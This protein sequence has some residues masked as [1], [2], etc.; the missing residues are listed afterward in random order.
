[1]KFRLD[2]ELVRRGLARSREEA[3]DF[4]SQGFVLV[5]GIRATKIASQVAI[6]D[7]IVVKDEG[8]RFVSRGGTKLSGALEYFGITSLQ[9]KIVLDAGASTGGFTDVALQLGATKVFAVDVGYGQLA[10]PL[11][12]NPQVE[13]IDRTN[14]R[15][16]KLED[17]G[18]KVDF[19]VADLSFISLSLVIEKFTE[20]IAEGGDLILL[21]KPQFEVGRDNLGS[22]GVVRDE[23]LRKSAVMKIAVQAFGL[24]WGTRG[25]VASSLPGPSGNVEYF[26]WLRQDS[27]LLRESDLDAA[28]ERGPK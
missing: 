27:E 23:Q 20:L 5:N 14:I 8:P 9:G 26:I 3:R 25:V 4:V 12:I 7:S 17:L 15:E 10:W 22:G 24:G 11:R 13:V 28:V 21:V 6:G 16:L 2:V 18:S 1:V 19:L